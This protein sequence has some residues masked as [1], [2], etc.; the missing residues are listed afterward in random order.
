MEGQTDRHHMLGYAIS[1]AVRQVSKAEKCEKNNLRHGSGD[2]NLLQN[3][4]CLWRGF[5]G[6]NQTF[7]RRCKDNKES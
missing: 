7:E 2:R 4:V 6:C 3:K 1:F 5:F